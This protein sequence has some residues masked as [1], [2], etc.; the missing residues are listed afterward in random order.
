VDEDVD[1]KRDLGPTDQQRLV[2]SMVNAQR[3]AEIP[4]PRRPWLDELAPVYDLSLLRQRTDSELLL[5]VAD[6]PDRQEQVPIYFQPDIDG[7]LAVYGTGGSGKSTVLRGLACAAAITP[8]G[9]PVH[10]Y[11]LDFGAGSLRMLEQLPHVGAVVR[12]DDGERVV[13]LLRMMRE[14]LEDRAQR[15]AAANASNIVEYRSLAG[16]PGN[17]GSVVRRVPRCAH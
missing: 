11:G 1:A 12:G 6:V 2:A 13:R 7:N 14:Q 9:G 16:R 5:G 3:L 4:A 15:F 17:A 10:V 8:R